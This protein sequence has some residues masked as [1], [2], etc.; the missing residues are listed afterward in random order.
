MRRELSKNFT[1]RRSTGERLPSG[2]AAFTIEWHHP[3]YSGEC[4]GEFAVMDSTRMCPQWLLGGVI[5]YLLNQ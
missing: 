5:A 2:T 3:F 4:Q 1:P